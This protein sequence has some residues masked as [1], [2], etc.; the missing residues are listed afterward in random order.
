MRIH[1]IVNEVEA[2]TM[3]NA[4][5]AVINMYHLHCC[6]PTHRFILLLLLLTCCFWII[7]IPFF[8]TNIRILDKRSRLL[9][10]VLSRHTSY[11]FRVSYVY[12]RHYYIDVRPQTIEKSGTPNGNKTHNSLMS[13][14]NL[15]ALLVQQQIICVEALPAINPGKSVNKH[16]YIS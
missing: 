15:S 4:S 7:F 14:I 3:K 6:W 9:S 12:K 1:L 8:H 2:H 16:R 10:E 5:S 11:C 13:W